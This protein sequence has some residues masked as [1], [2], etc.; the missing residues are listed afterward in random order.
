MERQ[1]ELGRAGLAAGSLG[2]LRWGQQRAA[3]CCLPFAHLA[4]L[5]YDVVVV[6]QAPFAHKEGGAKGRRQNPAN[7]K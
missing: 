5:G 3:A 6:D 7:H 2:A 4:G 1:V